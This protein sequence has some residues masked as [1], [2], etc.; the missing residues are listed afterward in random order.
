MKLLPS[1]TKRTAILISQGAKTVGFA[2]GYYFIE[3]SLYSHEAESVQAFFKWM[4]D[5][6]HR[7]SRELPFVESNLQ[8][9]YK[10][11]FLPEIK[12]SK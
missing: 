11:H 7:A 4:E 10:N 5:N 3:E 1:I 6:K 8:N 2:D 9:L 12:K